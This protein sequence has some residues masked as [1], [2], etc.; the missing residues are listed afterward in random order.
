MHKVGQRYAYYSVSYCHFPE[1]N[2]HFN[3]VLQKQ[4]S[5][6]FP[7]LQWIICNW[8]NLFSI[9]WFWKERKS[10]MMNW[11]NIFSAWL[12][13]FISCVDAALPWT[14]GEAHQSREK[15]RGQV[16]VVKGGVAWRII[17]TE[18]MCSMK[19][20]NR[21]Q[22]WRRGSDD[23]DDDYDLLWWGSG[24]ICMK[25]LGF[26]WGIRRFAWGDLDDEFE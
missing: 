10:D 1:G 2:I 25:G 18:T 15:V 3:K 21:G 11:L 22:N 8:R 26:K 24:R 14:R 13:L 5:L 12:L 17:I 6:L 16:G 20:V 7:K 9:I 23:G 4:N 19:G